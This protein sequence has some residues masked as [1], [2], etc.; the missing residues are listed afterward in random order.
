MT[1][2]SVE[3]LNSATGADFGARSKSF[4]FKELVCLTCYR[5]EIWYG[6][7]IF[8]NLKILLDKFFKISSIVYHL[9]IFSLLRQEVTPAVSFRSSSS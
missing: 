3:R 8:K 4:F 5:A 9:D 2:T 6:I 7:G 1:I